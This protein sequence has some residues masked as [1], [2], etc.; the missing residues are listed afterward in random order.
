MQRDDRVVVLGRGVHEVD[1]EP[2]LLA[3]V[4]AGDAPDALLVDALGRRRR[5]VHADR[6]A[7]A[8][9]AL[10]EQLRVD[11]HVD[12]AALVA[13][14]HRRELALGRLAGDGLR[15]EPFGAEGFGEVV[16]VAHA[17]RVDHAGHAR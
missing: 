13:R 9:P 16:R 10:G 12:L 11:Q 5:E 2:R 17:R 3:G 1:D 8:V 14:E 15:L 6:R 7:R 4:A